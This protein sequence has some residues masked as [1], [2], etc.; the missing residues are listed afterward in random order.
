MHSRPLTSFAGYMAI[1]L[2]QGRVVRAFL[3]A[4][5][6]NRVIAAWFRAGQPTSDAIHIYVFPEGD[7]G[8]LQ[9]EVSVFD[10]KCMWD[11]CWLEAGCRRGWISRML[12]VADEPISVQ[13]RG[14]LAIDWD[15]AV[16]TGGTILAA[17]AGSVVEAQA[18]TGNANP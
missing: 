8:T 15:T 4:P 14:R 5:E 9:A 16:P 17:D 3:V 2:P 6:S 7:V 13:L 18:L 10:G 11:A 12:L 1:D